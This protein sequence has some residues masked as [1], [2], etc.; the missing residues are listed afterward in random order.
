MNTLTIN[1][2][3]YYLNT[4]CNDKELAK[5]FGITT[6]EARKFINEAIT[7]SKHQKKLELCIYSREDLVTIYKD[8]NG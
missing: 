1:P 7:I 5:E 3:Q 6:H 8:Q 4:G 2:R